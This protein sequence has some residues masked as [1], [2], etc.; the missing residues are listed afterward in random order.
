MGLATRDFISTAHWHLQIKLTE[1]IMEE[2]CEIA[3]IWRLAIGFE[4]GAQLN[5]VF[6]DEVVVRCLERLSSRCCETDA[7]QTSV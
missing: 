7:D 6:C 1:R 3:R 2:H 4:R 5:D